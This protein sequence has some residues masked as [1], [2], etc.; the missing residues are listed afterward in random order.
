MADV[1]RPL[2]MMTVRDVSVSDNVPSMANFEGYGGFGNL[3]VVYN[4]GHAAFEFIEDRWGQEGVR[5]FLFGLRRTSIGGGGDV[6]EESLDISADD[7]DD[8]F[9][10]YLDDR[11]EAFRDKERPL[12]YGRDLAPD[13]EKR[14]RYPII[15]SIE[16][17]PTGELI[18]AMAINRKD[19]ELDVVLLSAADG[20]IVTKSHRRL[21]SV[22]GLRR[23][24]AARA[25]VQP[26]VVD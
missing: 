26:S 4:L 6:Y 16:G 19:G 13:I 8:E 24:H 14:P 22:D 17:S 12:D 23:H 1:W 25:A 5:Q 20:E 10:R 9:R 11:F 21:R 2:D 7:F 18:A 3:R 15:Y